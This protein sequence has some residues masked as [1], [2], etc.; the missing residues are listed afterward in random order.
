MKRV[1]MALI[2]LAAAGGAAG[3]YD[4]QAEAEA[5]PLIHVVQGGETLWSITRPIADDRGEDIR[6]II[7]Q[8]IHDNDIG[9]D[10][11]VYPGQQ[12]IIK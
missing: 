7:C 9:I 10:A 3:Y 8:V 6:E 11:A 2:V 5:A 1:I 4:R 12:L